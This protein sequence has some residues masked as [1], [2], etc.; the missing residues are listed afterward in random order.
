MKFH[1]SKND[2]HHLFGMVYVESPSLEI[3]QNLTGKSVE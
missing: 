2:F 1:A 3:F